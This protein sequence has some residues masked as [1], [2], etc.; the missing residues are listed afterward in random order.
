MVRDVQLEQGGGVCQQCWRS[1]AKPG[2]WF[3]RLTKVLNPLSGGLLFVGII[4]LGVFVYFN[5]GK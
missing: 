4:F 3:D 5:L 1:S 2:G